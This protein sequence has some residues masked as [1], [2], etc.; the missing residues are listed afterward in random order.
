M[1]AG[2]CS[3]AR[4]TRTLSCPCS[5]SLRTCRPVCDRGNKRYWTLEQRNM[6]FI[7][8]NKFL[9][10]SL[11]PSEDGSP[12]RAKMSPALISVPS[13]YHFSNGVGVP[14]TCASECEMPNIFL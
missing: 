4:G 7:V 11:T 5:S 12:R 9:F 10:I 3:C 1:S 8:L 14:I 13:L 6:G 2:S